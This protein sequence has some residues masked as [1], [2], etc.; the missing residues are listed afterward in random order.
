MA[1]AQDQVH[2]WKAE[3]LK[4]FS[5]CIFAIS[6]CNVKENISW[7][8]NDLQQFRNIESVQAC[9]EACKNQGATHF[10]WRGSHSMPVNKRNF[11]LCKD[12]ESNNP[13]TK[14]DV[15]SALTNCTST[16]QGRYIS[17]QTLIYAS[18]DKANQIE[19]STP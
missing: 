12:S 13:M 17:M 6:G 1:Q 18:C 2:T 3:R 15:Y 8:G 19:R 4:E 5:I 9:L 14:N 10:T 11:C 7:P 16:N